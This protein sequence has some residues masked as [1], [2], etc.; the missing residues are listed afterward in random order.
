MIARRTGCLIL[1]MLAA[2]RAS[3]PGPVERTPHAAA[4]PTMP[5]GVAPPADAASPTDA[6]PP[7]VEPTPRP[8]RVVLPAVPRVDTPPS[9]LRGD[10]QGWYLYSPVPITAA[11]VPVEY[12]TPL[13]SAFADLYNLTP[14]RRTHLE[15]MAKTWDAATRAE[16]RRAVAAAPTTERDEVAR[17]YGKDLELIGTTP[18][19]CAGIRV[20]MRPS[21]PLMR[22]FYPAF[23]HGCAEDRD[24]ALVLS[25]PL[26]VDEQWAFF[27]ERTARVVD[28]RP[29]IAT[30]RAQLAAPPQQRRRDVIAH[31]LLL[32]ARTDEPAGIDTLFALVESVDD[33]LRRSAKGSPEL[34]VERRRMY[35]AMVAELPPGPVRAQ[36]AGRCAKASSE[37]PLCTYTSITRFG[38]QFDDVAKRA[39]WSPSAARLRDV[40]CDGVPAQAARCRPRRDVVKQLRRAGLLAADVIGAEATSLASPAGVLVNARRAMLGASPTLDELVELVRPELGAVVVDTDPVS[41]PDDGFRERVYAGGARGEIVTS[42]YDPAGSRDARLGL[43]NTLLHRRG[44][45]WRVMLVSGERGD[46]L[47]AGPAVAL[48]AAVTAKLFDPARRP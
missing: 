41:A 35:G 22:V 48:E 1:S 31:A 21:E 25:L 37:H 11:Q 15:R 5:A 33:G 23:A 47:I 10:P 4:S 19:G 27:R 34:D 24:A 38:T 30:L 20:L 17:R 46:D 28:N 43:I 14:A 12:L 44:S 8:A 39:R 18:E 6:A 42:G 7:R 13:P 32:L 40:S 29:V 2:C 36:L 3:S 26:G 16:L 45:T 9:P